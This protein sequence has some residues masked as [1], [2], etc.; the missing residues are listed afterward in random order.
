MKSIFKF[1]GIIAFVAVIGFAMAACGNKSSGDPSG[2]PPDELVFT[3]SAAFDIP[4]NIIRTPI[5]NIDV[6]LGVSGGTPPYAYS[7]TGLPA[8][9]SIS[10][11]GIISG[12]PASLGPAGTATITVAD[13]DAASKSITIAYGIIS[14]SV[15][16]AGYYYTGGAPAYIACYWKDG[17]K[18]DLENVL[19]QAT[20]I[21]VVGSDVYIAGWYDNGT[22]SIACYWKNG[23][24]TDLSTVRSEAYAIAVVGSNVYVTGAYTMAYTACYWVNTTQTVPT[25]GEPYVIAVDG[26]N[27]YFAG[28]Y[29]NGGTTEACYWKDGTLIPLPQPSSITYSY[30]TAIAIV[31]S[32]VHIAGIYNDGTDIPCYWVNGTTPTDLSTVGTMDATAIAVVGSDVYVAGND[33][34][35]GLS[36][37]A[38]YWKNGTKT[39]LST[40]LSEAL[41]I[42]VDGS[43][44][45]IVGRYWVGSGSG[46]IACYWKN[47][48]KTDL[49][50]DNARATGIALMVE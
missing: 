41:A 33:Q 29:N 5:T 11:T 15:Y 2:T 43:D 39:N 26:S 13:S 21:T 34:T 8:G 47:G 28:S 7:A 49:S 45:Y 6:S 38:C 31:G 1:L 20:A 42:A 16:A 46:T 37:I 12:A 9:I 22:T 4:A 27:V 24:K 48:T 36:S 3:D 10:S 23:E 25:D 19:S 50:D 17:V 40:V 30:A 35:T 32:D 44:V 14:P 18:T